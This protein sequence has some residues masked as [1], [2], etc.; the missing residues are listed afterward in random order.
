ME[1][2]YLNTTPAR[3]AKAAAAGDTATAAA[4]RVLKANLLDR[5]GRARGLAS[6]DRECSRVRLLRPSRAPRGPLP[7]AGRPSWGGSP[8]ASQRP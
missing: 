8:Q 4:T 6:V 2:A 7:V 1:S 3:P 5:D